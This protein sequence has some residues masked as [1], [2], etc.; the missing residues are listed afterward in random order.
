MWE[1]NFVFDKLQFDYN[2]AER[3]SFYI[4]SNWGIFSLLDLDVHISLKYWEAF[5]HYC[6]KYIFCAS[7]NNMML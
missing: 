4:E 7:F 2:M 6:V 5:N 3:E 1:L